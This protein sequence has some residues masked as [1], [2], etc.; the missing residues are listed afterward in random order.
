MNATN[1]ILIFPSD[2]SEMD[3]VNIYNILSYRTG[4]GSGRINLKANGHPINAQ[5]DNS[6]EFQNEPTFIS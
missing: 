1:A 2:P 5:L 4:S 3:K 6:Y